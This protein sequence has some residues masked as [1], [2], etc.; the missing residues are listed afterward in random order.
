M[1]NLE[2]KARYPDIRKAHRLAIEIG[3]ERQ[4]RRAQRDTYFE[5]DRGKL[6]LRQESGRAAELIAYH[7]PGEAGAE[8]SD[9]HI[10]ETGDAASLLQVLST[11][12]QKEIVVQKQRELYLWKNVRIHLDKVDNLGVFLEFEAIVDADN[13]MS[14]CKNRIDMLIDHFEIEQSDLVSDGYYELLKESR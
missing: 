1:Q 7:R 4:W 6:K 14:A 13:D 2:L 3:A 5:V 11:V 10:Y 12:L 9:Y 8:I